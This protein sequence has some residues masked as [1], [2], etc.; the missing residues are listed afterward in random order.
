MP[1]Q[2]EPAGQRCLVCGG[3]VR[4][5]LTVPHLRL[6]GQCQFVACQACQTIFDAARL[7]DEH[8]I[9]SNT[10]YTPSDIKFYVEYGA[11]IEHSALLV[12]LLQHALAPALAAGTRPRFLDVGT[13]FGFAVSIAA[14]CGWDAQ[15][16]EP[17]DFGQAGAQLLEINIRSGYLAE[18][19][20]EPETF[21]CVLISD[22]I[23]HVGQ[24]GALVAG[25]LKLLK[26]AG[27][28]LL[29]TPN[30]AVITQGLE[31]DI[32]DVLSPG[33]HLTI[34]SPAGITRVLAD[35][36]AQDVRCFFQGGTS[37][38][39]GLFVLAAR[40][41]GVLPGELPW[42]AIRAE[43]AALTERYLQQLAARKERQ[44]QPDMI[45][46]G[47]LFR[48][49][50]IALLRGDHP[51]AYRYQQRLAQLDGPRAW[52][53][54]AFTRLAGLGFAALV[55]E[56]PAYAGLFHYY[57]GVLQSEHLGDRTAAAREFGIARRLF[58][59]EKQTQIFPR[60]GWPERAGYQEAVAQ[61][62]S[63]QA[64]AALST[65][66]AL[67]EAPQEI[68]AELWEPLYAHRAAAQWRAGRP[69]PAVLS[70]GQWL[71]RRLARLAG[72]WIRPAAS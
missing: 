47:A 36:Q 58:Q 46:R 59:I 1:S 35:H 2:F 63:G 13:A 37:G 4:P 53:P 7:L 10:A 27:V 24:P 29:T 42:P 17:S 71:R 56:V 20:F 64:A 9:G 5:L 32:T 57:S 49:L 19:A 15:G 68:P 12:T 25:A 48:L 55:Q 62:N 30:G 70:A 65:F 66:Q 8:Y 11:G 45:Y 22:V 41:P 52:P 69:G 26:P 40:A 72:R 6:A 3:A 38:Q 60:T 16:L 67:L 33:Y 61:L 34:F 18:G 28:L 14:E 31:S 44:N 50:E 23:E 54:E 51:T 43:A 39:K 21:D